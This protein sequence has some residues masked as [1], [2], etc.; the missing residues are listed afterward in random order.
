[1]AR[2]SIQSLKLCNADMHVVVES[3]EGIGYMLN[4]ETDGHRYTVVD[5]DAKVFLR[6]NIADIYAVLDGVNYK[7]AVLEYRCAGDEMV[8]LPADHHPSFTIPIHH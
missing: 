7:E 8:G 5:D 6:Q 3:F 1:M 2:M 4:V